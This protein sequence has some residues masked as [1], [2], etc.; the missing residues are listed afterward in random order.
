MGTIFSRPQAPAPLPPN[1]NYENLR[2]RNNQVTIVGDSNGP[3]TN[4]TYNFSIRDFDQWERDV[5]L[6]NLARHIR[7]HLPHHRFSAPTLH[8]AAARLP[9]SGSGR[10]TRNVLTGS[11]PV[12]TP[13]SALPRAVNR[14]SVA[15]STSPAHTFNDS[16]LP[17]RHPGSV[18]PSEDNIDSEPSSGSDDQIGQLQDNQSPRATQSS[19]PEQTLTETSRR[20]RLRMW[21]AKLSLFVRSIYILVALIICGIIGGILGYVMRKHNSAPPADHNCNCT[22]SSLTTTAWE[23]STVM[24]TWSS[25]AATSLDPTPT[26]SSSTWSTSDAPFQTSSVFTST[27]EQTATSS[28]TSTSP[29]DD[30]PKVTTT[31]WTTMFTMTST[32]VSSEATTT[33]FV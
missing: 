15:E 13:T 21:W 4:I 28:D 11:P 26:E 24:M 10:T 33:S 9:R 5:R 30:A 17:I 7:E 3:Q 6:H 20:R 12:P 31:V 19:D 8:P 1:A 22:A 23:T 25:I 18:I 29:T 32:S 27:P 16:T 14:N 2:F